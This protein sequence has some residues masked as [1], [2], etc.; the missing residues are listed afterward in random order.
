MRGKYN[1]PYIT[2]EAVDELADQLIER[3][4]VP[5]IELDVLIAFVNRADR[6][7]GPAC[8][9][10]ELAARGTLKNLAIA[11]SELVEYELVLRS[12]GY[13]E[14]SIGEDLKAFSQIRGVK[15][16][17][18]HARNPPESYR[19]PTQAPFDLLRFAARGNRAAIRRDHNLD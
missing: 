7:H 15:I 1:D 18:S 19:A 2:Y 10:F 12:K 16:L 3:G 11:S 5:V 8:R 6:L 4:L 17:P 13:G 9:I 14:E